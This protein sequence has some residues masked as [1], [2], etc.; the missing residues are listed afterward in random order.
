MAPYSVHTSQEQGL[1]VKQE[2]WLRTNRRALLTAMVLP[3]VAVF[4]GAYLCG[5]DA[6][7]ARAAGATLAVGG[8]GLSLLLAVQCF[9]P[10]LALRDDRLRFWLRS[11]P[12]LEVPVEL[13]E[14]FFLGHTEAKLS[15]GSRAARVV[16][17][18][19]RL[20][21]SAHQYKQRDVKPAL[22]HWSDGY[23]AICGTWCEP[24]SLAVANRLNARLSAAQQHHKESS[25]PT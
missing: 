5:A 17:I 25:R 9:K 16:T 11:G 23:I 6:V 21:E 24:L 12:P 10:R 15:L 8:S 4:A 14:C 22:G 7:A 18:V 20:A 2:V 13:V 1:R 19:A 3:M